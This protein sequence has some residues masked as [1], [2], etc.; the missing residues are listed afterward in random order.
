MKTND[1]Q[2]II[3]EIDDWILHTYMSEI[4][5]RET[6]TAISYLGNLPIHISAFRLSTL[7][8]LITSALPTC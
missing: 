3:P 5:R 6:A 4:R 1:Y 8:N 7:N 2:Q